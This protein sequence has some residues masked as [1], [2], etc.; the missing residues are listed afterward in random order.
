[1]VHVVVQALSVIRTRGR[2]G[3]ERRERGSGSDAAIRCGVSEEQRDRIRRRGLVR[4]VPGPDCG[5][6]LRG[7]FRPERFPG[8]EVSEFLARASCSGTG[9]LAERD[10]SVE[11][12][13]SG[14]P[15]FPDQC[16]GVGNVTPGL[17]TGRTGFLGHDGQNSTFRIVR[18]S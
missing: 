2:N 18:D 12:F 14:T 15:L 1:M 6:V 11:L 10:D 7:V 13:L 3:G 16:A 4:R 9:A 8:T 17:G 5:D